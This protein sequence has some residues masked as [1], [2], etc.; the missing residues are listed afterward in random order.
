MGAD[1]NNISWHLHNMIA[2]KEGIA[3]PYTVFKSVDGKLIA[4]GTTVPSDAATGY[5][6][7]C[8]FI[9][10]GGSAGA[11]VYIN[12]G[13]DTS[14][15]FKALPSNDYGSDAA[16]GTGGS[17]LIW[18]G[19]D[20]EG[21]ARDPS[22]GV[23]YFT[24]FLENGEVSTSP[25]FQTT[26]TSGGITSVADEVGGVAL[27]S[28]EANASADDGINAQLLSCTVKPAAGVNIH[29]E[30]RCKMV[31][32]GDDQYFIGLFEP[33][34]TAAIAG[35]VIE[36]TKDKVG[37]FRDSGASPADDYL[38]TIIAN[39]AAQNESADETAVVDDTYINLGFVITGLTSVKFYADGALLQTNTTTASI[40]NAV[41]CPTLVAQCEQ[42]SADADLSVDWMRLVQVGGRT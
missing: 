19:V 28:S 8:I 16:G 38:T 31:D 29:F 26:V 5:A 21:I 23:A 2:A 30:C 37:F 17:P 41:I 14:A 3:T 12:E 7:G 39:G 15:N 27:F 10:T 11:Q 20:F 34:T 13:S 25:W 40:P 24:D 1:R 6:E 35:G 33:G 32:T 36:D 42:T 18:D 22:R 9:K 4:Y